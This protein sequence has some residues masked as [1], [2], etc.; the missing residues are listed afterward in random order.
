MWCPLYWGKSMCG[1]RTSGVYV[2]SAETE[3]AYCAT[4]KYTSCPRYKEASKGASP[5]SGRKLKAKKRCASRG[6]LENETASE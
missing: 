3:A 4:D 1:A 5:A 2:P 6:R